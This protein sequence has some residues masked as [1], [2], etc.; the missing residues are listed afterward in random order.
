MSD[1]L[2]LRELSPPCPAAPAVAMHLIPQC[3]FFPALHAQG[4]VMLLRDLLLT[5]GA[6]WGAVSGRLAAGGF[7]G[8]RSFSCPLPV[9]SANCAD[10]W[11]LGFRP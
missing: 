10:P 2:Q 8:G 6:V 11:G 1:P 4:C 7:S 5:G 9:F 3:H